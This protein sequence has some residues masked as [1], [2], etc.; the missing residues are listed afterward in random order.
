MKDLFIGK[1]QK[2]EHL[3]YESRL[4]FATESENEKKVEIDKKDFAFIPRLA[5][6]LFLTLSVLS[7][8]EN[9]RGGQIGLGKKNRGIYIGLRFL[10]E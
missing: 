6:Q 1:D 4:M 8:K 5:N 9:E 3:N 10:V 7:K 2:R